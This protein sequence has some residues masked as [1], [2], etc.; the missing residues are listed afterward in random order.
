[1]VAKVAAVAGASVAVLRAARLLPM[2]ARVVAARFT[3]LEGF[4]V[5]PCATGC[6][7]IATPLLSLV[8]SSCLSIRRAAGA[9]R[10]LAFL[11]VT[12]LA[13]AFLASASMR[14]RIAARLLTHVG[15]A[16]RARS[17]LRPRLDPVFRR[18]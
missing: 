16:V 12:L 5:A 10:T 18:R 15:C 14:A 8:A 6:G 13:I 11:S 17:P 7:V 2:R 9:R 1:L 3:R 4:C